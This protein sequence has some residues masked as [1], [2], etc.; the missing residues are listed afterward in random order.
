MK[1]L[2]AE[3]ISEALRAASQGL[4]LNRHQKVDER[5]K[6]K[7]EQVKKDLRASGKANFNGTMKQVGKTP[8]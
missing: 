5:L 7:Q 6:I 2:T 4:R 3:K 1:K 8:L